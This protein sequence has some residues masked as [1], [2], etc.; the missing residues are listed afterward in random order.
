MNV[1]KRLTNAERSDRRVILHWL[2]CAA[3]APIP[4]T[5]GR[6]N[7][8]QCVIFTS[9]TRNWQTIVKGTNHHRDRFNP[10]DRRPSIFLQLFSISPPT[11]RG[12]PTRIPLTTIY[13][14]VELL[15]LIVVC[16]MFRVTP[17]I[18]V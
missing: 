8:Y 14:D 3:K 12:V 7:G 6:L 15:F 5:N 2:S 4:R 13:A 11:D 1:D 10:R 16:G 17:V 18:V 9:Q